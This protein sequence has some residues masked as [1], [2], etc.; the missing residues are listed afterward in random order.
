MDLFNVHQGINRLGDKPRSA[1]IDERNA[2]LRWLARR[3]DIAIPADASF[4]DRGIYSKAADAYLVSMPGYGKQPV[5]TCELLDEDGNVIRTITLPAD[6]KGKGALPM[7]AKQVQEWTGLEKV[8][9]RRALKPKAPEPV[10]PVAPQPVKAEPVE[11]APSAQGM[12]ARYGVCFEAPAGQAA[13]DNLAP[14]RERT[15]A[16]RRSILRAW[17]MRSEMRAR[18]DLDRR[19][20][21][22]ANG[23]NRRLHEALQDAEATTDAM[24]AERDAAMAEIARLKAK[25]HHFGNEV[26]LDDVARLTGE[27]DAARKSLASASEERDRLA[28]AVGKGAELLEAMTDRALRAEIALKTAAARQSREVPSAPYRVNLAGVSF[29]VAA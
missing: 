4:S 17:R 7:T 20:L 27:R 9:K 12:P 13:N 14:K 16:E 2:Y 26:R 21:L 11:Q 18:A 15:A 19:A 23:D 5:P 3:D 1:T 29:E 22:A 25:P 28:R 24:Q 8:R 10:Q 6:P